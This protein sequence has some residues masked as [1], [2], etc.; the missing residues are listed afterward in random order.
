MRIGNDVT[1]GAHAVVMPDVEIGDGAIV[2]VG[3]VVTKG[4]RIGCAEIWG[5]VPAQ[6]IAR[7]TDYPGAG[8]A[9][10]L[11]AAKSDG[12]SASAA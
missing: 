7:R 8:M 5:G 12:T 4:T 3:A 6:R 10:D 9:T 1:I 2:S 11:S